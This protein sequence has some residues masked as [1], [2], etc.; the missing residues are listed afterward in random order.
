MDVDSPRVMVRLTDP[1]HSRIAKDWYIEVEGQQPIQQTT[2]P[3][4]GAL[5]LENNRYGP[6]R[7]E[8]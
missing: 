8:P 7:H 3:E 6:S 4:C 1:A 2:R 5:A